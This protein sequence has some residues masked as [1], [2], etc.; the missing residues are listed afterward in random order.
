MFRFEAGPHKYFL[1]SREIPGVTSILDR[2][3]L[4]S[5]FAKQPLAAERGRNVHHGLALFGV[6]NLDFS[7]IDERIMGWGLSGFRFF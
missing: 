6:D 4:V 2:A 1:N 5:P 7:T 3:G